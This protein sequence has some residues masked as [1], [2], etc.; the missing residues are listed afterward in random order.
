[1]LQHPVLSRIFESQVSIRLELFMERRGVLPTTQFA[2]WKG[3]GT[4]DALLTIK[5]PEC[6]RD[7][8]EA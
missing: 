7:G 3:F 5:F 4:G 6:F 2:Y 8:A 1:M